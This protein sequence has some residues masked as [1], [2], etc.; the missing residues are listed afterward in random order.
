MLFFKILLGLGEVII[1]FNSNLILLLKF[2]ITQ[3]GDITPHLRRL[4]GVAHPPIE[5]SGN[6]SVHM[7]A[8]S[9]SNVSPIPSEVISG[10]SEP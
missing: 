5:V 7:S 10:V 9:P 1:L 6:V 8:K 2:L 3:M 4:D